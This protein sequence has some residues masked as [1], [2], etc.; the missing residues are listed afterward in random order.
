MPHIELSIHGEHADELLAKQPNILFFFPDQH[1]PDWL[2]CN[3]ESPVRTPNLDRLCKHGIRFTNAF[4]PS[5]V[6]SPARACLA[7]GKT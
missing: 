2:G 1:R 3:P 5:P 6:C 4:T 7:T